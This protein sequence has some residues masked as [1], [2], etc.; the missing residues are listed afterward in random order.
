MKVRVFGLIL[1]TVMLSVG[2]VTAQE[3]KLDFWNGFTGPDRVQVEGL[4]EKFNETHPGIKVEMEIMP[5]D[6]LFQKLLPSLAIGKGPDI[7]AFDTTNIPRYA[8][9]N[10]I[11]PIDEFY[12]E[13]L[14]KDVLIPSLY[15][16]LQWKGKAYGAPMNYTSLLLY[17]NRDL[18]EEA[19]LNPDRPPQTWDEL[20][21]YALKLTKDT[22][23]NG[24]VDQYGFVIAARETIPMWPI[25]TWSDGGRL[26]EDGEVKINEPQ[27]VKAIDSIA[28]L[29]KDDQVSPIGL[30]GAECDKLFETQKAAM[31]FC[32][33][34]MVNG[35]KNSGVNFAVAQVPEG[36]DGRRTTLG[37][38]V[39]MVLN[40]ASE[41]K[42]EAA[43]EFF[44]FWNSTESQVYWSLGSGFP[45]NRID[46]PEKEL[47]ENPYVVEFS[48]ASEDSRFYLPKIEEFSEIDKDIII[49]ALEKI[50]HGQATTQEALDE[51]AMKIKMLLE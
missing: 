34:W 49:P 3:V 29:I 35:F 40:K 46:I 45:P 7:A 18:F 39:A 47:A 32:G 25:V 36:K 50:L 12:G 17:Y 23:N 4:V 44:K 10:V 6:S 28:K 13:Y 27:A 24:K 51:A 16:N 15:T 5:W 31:Y 19:G 48:K 41:D 14:D 33:P 20:R 9:A 2:S 21:E 1:L 43:Y 26:I 22:D 38:S 42:K 37:T 11:I 8:E 30:T